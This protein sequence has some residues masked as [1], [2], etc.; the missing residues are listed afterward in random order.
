[1]CTATYRRASALLAAAALTLIAS[2]EVA[3]AQTRTFACAKHNPITVTV[4]GPATV[5][6]G[7]IEGKMLQMK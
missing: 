6:A 7:P 3:S 2:A 1:M 4:T 5:S